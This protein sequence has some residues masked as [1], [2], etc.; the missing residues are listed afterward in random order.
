MLLQVKLQGGE[1]ALKDVVHYVRAE[2]NVEE[3]EGLEIVP[4]GWCHPVVFRLGRVHSDK[5][6]GVGGAEGAN[7]SSVSEEGVVHCSRNEAVA[8]RLIQES[9]FREGY[10][11][12]SS[13]G[14]EVDS[15]LVVG[16]EE[17]VTSQGKGGQKRWVGVR[18]TA[19]NQK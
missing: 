19:L 16:G 8:E 14:H 3:G 7:C 9:G 17:V 6:G 5:G 10:G 11:I 1:R 15:G 18:H 13:E 12:W 4:S 2:G